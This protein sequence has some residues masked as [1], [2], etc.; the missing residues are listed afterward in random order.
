MMNENC[1]IQRSEQV[2]DGGFMSSAHGKGRLCLRT[3]K[4]DG[5]AYNQGCDDERFNILVF[6]FLSFVMEHIGNMF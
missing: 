3:M 4:Q 1:R 2:T 5:D 6:L